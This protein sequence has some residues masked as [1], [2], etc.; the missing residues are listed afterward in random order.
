VP[1]AGLAAEGFGR[2]PTVVPIERVSPPEV[3]LPVKRYRLVLSDPTGQ[4]ERLRQRI[5][6][7]IREGDP[8][9][10][11]ADDAPFTLTVTVRDFLSGTTHGIDGTHRVSD[12]AG[13]TVHE[14]RLGASNAGVLVK[15]SDEALVDIAARDVVRIVAIQRYRSAALVP[16]GRLEPLIPLAERGDWAGYLAAAERLA[17]LP[18]EADAYRRYAVALGH[19]G[20]AAR[21]PDLVATVQHLRDAVAHN[22][23]AARAKPSESHFSR[24]FMPLYRAL[25]TPGTPPMVWVA[26]RAMERWESLQRMQA[27]LAAPAASPGALDNRSVLEL[28]M[29]GR[30]DGEVLAAIQRAPRVRFA[31]DRDDMVA[32][33][34]AGVSWR[35]IDAMRAR[36]GLPP[37]EL[38]ITPDGW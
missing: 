12:R 4:A 37:R 30:A 9:L 15:R 6:A 2:V 16:K 19:E 34:K 29:A 17:A 38:W 10:R 22:I 31:L 21:S 8:E 7:L 23:A 36:A 3:A 11:P 5:E 18:G 14:G 26:P 24:Q 33:S 1:R 35:V 28:M 13:R 25:G 27:W 32:L 20:L